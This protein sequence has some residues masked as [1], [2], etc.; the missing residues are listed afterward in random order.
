MSLDTWGILADQYNKYRSLPVGSATEV[1]A[2][3]PANPPAKVT[4]PS[5]VYDCN[6]YEPRPAAELQLKKEPLPAG[7]GMACA[8]RPPT[9]PPAPA[10]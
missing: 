3:V 5:E 1:S 9:T 7:E 6:N 4:T 2:Y 10:S 8:S